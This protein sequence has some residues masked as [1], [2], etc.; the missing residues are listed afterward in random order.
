MPDQQATASRGPGILL[1]VLAT[2]CWSTSGIFISLIHAETGITAV[3]LAFW[4]DL[5]TFLI[6]LLGIVIFRRDLLKVSRRDLPWLIAMGMISIGF[7]HVLWNTAV[8]LNGASISTVIQS[9]APIFVTIM[10]WLLWKEPLTLR[11]LVAV[12]LAVAGTVLI[13]RLDV[14]GGMQITLY[15]V[16]IALLAAVAYGT[17][18]LFGKKLGNSYNP[19]TILI[20]VFGFGTLA[21]AP[22]QFSSPLPWPVTQKAAFSLIALVMLTTITGFVL[23]TFGLRRLQASVASITANTEV[24]FASILAYI[25]LGERLNMTQIVGAVLIV[26]GVILISLPVKKKLKA[27]DQVIA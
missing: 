13:S 10:G 26:S 3:G 15:G 4:R 2:A 21:L 6:L 24:L 19:W 20:Y 17:Y 14:Q 5:S 18:S 1:V 9:N 27:A 25:I 7:F 23:Y 12:V 16:I 11:K 8:L 22:L